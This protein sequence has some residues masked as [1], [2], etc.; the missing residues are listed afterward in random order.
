M[1]DDEKIIEIVKVALKEN[2]ADTLFKLSNIFEKRG[3]F[4]K[5][6]DEILSTP[7]TL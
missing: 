3:R 7:V 2:H 5:E 1:K 6:L 4:A